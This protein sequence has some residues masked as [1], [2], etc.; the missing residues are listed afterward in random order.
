[1]KAMILA[2]GRG[3]RMGALTAACP[4]P[5]LDVGGVALIERHLLRLAASGIQEVVINL[6]YRGAQIRAALGDGERF[7][8][9]IRYSDEGEPPLETAGGIVEALPLLGVEPFLLVNADVLTDFDFR[10]LLTPAMRDTLVL[11]PN[12]AHH[13]NGDFGLDE[14]GV[15]RAAPPL[16]TYGG[17]AVFDP[18]MFHDLARGRRPLK[19]LLDAGIARQSLRGLFYDGDWI[20]VGTPER[21][22]EARA[23][24][25]ARG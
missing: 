1:M 11:V 9:A 6:S 18:M 22:D 7:R 19:P 16:L 13:P 24:V 3:D 10:T 20:D 4:K 15:L 23:L 25:K 2:A 21:L 8:L 12:P 14:A 5:L 17:I